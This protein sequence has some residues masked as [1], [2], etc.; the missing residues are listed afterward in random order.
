MEQN[1]RARTA[2]VCSLI[3][4]PSPTNL[5]SYSPVRMRKL[6]KAFFNIHIS[7]NVSLWSE[8]ADCWTFFYDVLFFNSALCWQNVVLSSSVGLVKA[9]EVYKMAVDCW[10]WPVWDFGAAVWFPADGKLQGQLFAIVF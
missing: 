5:N 4:Y 6:C 9:H 10:M 1:E 8:Y 3:N 2:P 7:G